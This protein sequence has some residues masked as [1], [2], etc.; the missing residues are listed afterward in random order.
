MRR[1]QRNVSFKAAGF[2]NSRDCH[3][4]FAAKLVGLR[5]QPFVAY[6]TKGCRSVPTVV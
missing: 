2:Y 1:S 5:L 6:A 4:A 3:V